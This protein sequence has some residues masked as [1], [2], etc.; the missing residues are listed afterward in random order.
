MPRATCDIHNY[1]VDQTLDETRLSRH[2]MP[3]LLSLFAIQVVLAPHVDP[4][5]FRQAEGVIRTALNLGD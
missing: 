5:F 2:A 3:R 4:S 1:V